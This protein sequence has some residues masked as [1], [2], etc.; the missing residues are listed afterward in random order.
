MCLTTDGCEL[1]EGHLKDAI[2]LSSGG[3]ITA[4]TI[5]GFGN[6]AVVGPHT[7]V[8]LKCQGQLVDFMEYYNKRKGQ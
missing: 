8:Q 2:H 1:Y 5:I 4:G 7:H 6:S 3:F